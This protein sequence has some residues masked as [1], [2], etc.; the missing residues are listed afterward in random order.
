M[1]K[2]TLK[3]LL[4]NLTREQMIDVILEMYDARKDAREYL[5][6]FVDP[7]ESAMAEK[8]KSI[9][10]KEFFP[11]RG[12]AKG[13]TSVCRRAIKEFTTLHPS[14]IHIADVKFHFV[15]T[16]VKYGVATR[17]WLKESQENTLRTALRDLLDY[18][19]ANDLLDR[20]QK[21]IHSIIDT[22]SASRSAKARS[23]VDVYTDFLAEN[24]LSE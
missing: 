16:I 7:N 18:C 12:H 17:W 19:F 15:E 23:A 10:S 1:S 5:E 9:I 11:A 13:R 14:P 20:S 24:A 3:K 21:R 4:T 6:Y 22:L 2:T 8:A